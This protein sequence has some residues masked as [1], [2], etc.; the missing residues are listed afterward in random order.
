[1][2]K[3]QKLIK[4]T[5]ILFVFSLSGFLVILT[6]IYFYLSPE[7]PSIDSLQDIRFQIPLRIY[8]RD[9]KLIAE[10]GEKR[11]TPIRYED[12][13]DKFIK[14]VLAAEDQ[15]F[16]KHSG[17]DIKGLTRAIKLLLQNR[18]EIRGGGSTIT[19]QLARALFLDKE[20]KFRRKFKEI[21]LAIQ[22]EKELTKEQ[23]LELYFNEI[24]LGK[25]AY[26][27]QA[28][29]NVY[30]NKSIDELN[31]AQLAM[32]AGL[33]KAPSTFNPVNNPERAIVR[34]DWILGRM[35]KLGFIDQQEHDNAVAQGITASDYGFTAEA[36][37]SYLAEMIR[38]DLFAQHGESIYTEGYKVISTIDS[39]LQTYANQAVY[40]GAHLYDERHGYKGVLGRAELP[41][42]NKKVQEIILNFKKENDSIFEKLKSK[43]QTEQK[44]QNQAESIPEDRDLK[45]LKQSTLLQDID[46]SIAL[47]KFSDI[48]LLKVALALYV[49]ENSNKA[50]FLLKDNRLVSVTAENILWAAPYIDVNTTGAIPTQISQVLKSG[51]VV[52]LRLTENQQWRL[53]QL[54]GVQS[55]FVAMNPNNGF[56][57]ALVGGYN[58]HQSK[59][60]RVVQGG[61]QAGSIFKPFVYT[62]ALE[63]GYTAASIINDAPVVFDDTALE[64]A[65][66]PENAGGR[67][68]GP[69]R[70]REALYRSRNLVSIRILRSMNIQDTINS[71]ERFGFEKEQLPNNLSLAL[72]SA[73]LTPM[74]VANAFSVFAN[75]GY[76][77]YP[78]YIY[79]IRDINDK[80]IYKVNPITVCHDCITVAQKIVADESSSNN[81]EVPQPDNLTN[82]ANNEL[83]F[84]LGGEADE[85]QNIKPRYAQS[86]I[87]PRVNYI[88]DSILGDV[89]RRGTAFKAMELGRRDLRG[90]TGTTNDQVDAWFTGYNS[91]IVASVWLGFDKPQTLGADEFGATGALPIWIAFMEKALAGTEEKN[92]PQPPNMITVKI[93]AVTGEAAKPGDSNTIFEIF[94]EEFAPKIEAS[95]ATRTEPK[96]GED[97]VPEQLF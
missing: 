60:N 54:P 19:M 58:F 20:Q 68:D 85:I 10:F 29:A 34:R 53:A 40:Q 84:E 16:F 38:N 46:F 18:G 79:E 15:D 67:F 91:D 96:L 44:S 22:I 42:L 17:I 73:S 14:A 59:F 88:I 13:P 52:Y 80:V 83:L 21:I 5:L 28:A 27:I 2:L 7:L 47:N 76:R 62:K 3:I 55:A 24:Y 78:S 48:A 8:S 63:E 6:S 25:R 70:F 69:T 45:A 49:D 12:V 71:M 66:R 56:V 50:I 74:Q 9:E 86:V 97:V 33:P 94:R 26:G 32:I 23:I 35:L 93:N 75:G 95:R 39:K 31:L 65:W 64:E 92:L 57:L 82:S 41:E 81:N 11:R 87:E 43:T 4:A 37:A 36:E 89:V 30:Y 77:V 72:G 51:D 61:R 90:K 1:M